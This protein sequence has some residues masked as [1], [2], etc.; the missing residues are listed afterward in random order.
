MLLAFA[1]SAQAQ[2]NIKQS[3]ATQ[4]IVFFMVDSTDHITGKTGL[5]PTVTLSKNAAAFGAAAGA[6]TE[7]SSGWY[8]L[9]ANATDS[10]TLGPLL[11]RATATGADATDSFIG[12]VIA[13]D[14]IV[15]AMGLAIQKNVIYS[16]FAFKLVDSGDN[17]TPETGLTP[18]VQIMK[19][20]A[21][22]AAA[23]NAAVE[24]TVGWYHIEFT[25]AEMNADIIVIK[26]TATGA[27]TVEY[28]LRTN[29]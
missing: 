6:V 12:N 5:T 22:F 4:H 10:G 17:K 13:V 3:T 15:A 2:V 7:I 24:D 9:A 1:A 16:N 18:T 29:Q 26:I 21:T 23:T 14:P 19:D 8:K 28:V 20:G 25:A 11:L 27:N